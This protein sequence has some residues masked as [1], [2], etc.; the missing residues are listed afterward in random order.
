MAQFRRAMER[1]GNISGRFKSSLGEDLIGS[2]RPLMHYP[3]V[4]VAAADTSVALADWRAQTKL[5]FFAAGVGRPLLRLS[6]FS[7]RGPS[8]SP[9]TPRRAQTSR[10]KQA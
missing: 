3:I 5:Q 9:P 6:Y 4:I 10:K 1:D 7:F 2:V 8:G